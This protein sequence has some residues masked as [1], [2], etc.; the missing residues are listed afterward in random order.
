MSSVQYPIPV[1]HQQWAHYAVD[2]IHRG[3]TGIE[4]VR[5]RDVLAN[6]NVSA[7]AVWI[8]R[9]ATIR[10]VEAGF[11]IKTILETFPGSSRWDIGALVQVELVYGVKY[12]RTVRNGIPEDNL[13]NLP[14]V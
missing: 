14:S 9:D 10:R 7:T 5:M 2:A 11:V 13:G 3:D 8:S 6:G 1:T 12:L 4:A